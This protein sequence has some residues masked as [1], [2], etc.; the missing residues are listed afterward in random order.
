MKNRCDLLGA[1]LLVAG[2]LALAGCGT[3]QPTGHGLPDQVA[4][5]PALEPAPVLALPA[6][7]LGCTFV[8]QQRLTVFAP[9]QKPQTLDAMLEVDA[10]MVRLALFHM[11]QR[12]G[13]LMWDGQQLHADLSRW[14]PDVLK[15]AQ[16][17]SDMQLAL[18]PLDVVQQA[19][20]EG[21]EIE[22]NNSWRRL[23]YK[24]E[25]R[26]LIQKIKVN[27]L[28]ITYVPAGWRLRIESADGTQPCA[29]EG[30]GT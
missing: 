14:W 12:M 20:P 21:W 11:G 10:T 29:A 2:T 15:P 16:V 25:R 28:E 8:V 4:L 27:T 5:E 17:L 26:I 9:Q 24:R 22:E 3:V 7:A 6:Q 19:L 23:L 13:T 30:L 1:V 18:W